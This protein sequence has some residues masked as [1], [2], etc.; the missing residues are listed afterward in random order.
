MEYKTPQELRELRLALEDRGLS[1]EVGTRS[2]RPDHLLKHLNICRAI[3]ANLC[4][5]VIPYPR[6]VES[7]Q[8]LKL[9]ADQFHD[10]GVR[11]AIENHGLHT[12]EE[13]TILFETLNHPAI[14]S[15]VDTIN[16]FSLLETPQQVLGTLLPY[17]FNVHIKDFEIHRVHHQMGFEL[18]GAPLGA[19][20]LDMHQTVEMICNSGRNPT[21]ILEQWVPFSEDVDS[22]VAT[23]KNWLYQSI[24]FLKKFLV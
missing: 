13:L 14:G 8:D 18:H 21:I 7:L 11:L 19:G 15:C 24:K 17:S 1:V 20:Q 9:V 12:A 5:T 4:R 2:T 6:A 10:H 22:V 16:S 23:E 3:G